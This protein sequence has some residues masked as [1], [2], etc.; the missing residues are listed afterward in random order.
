MKADEEIR[1]DLVGDGYD[2]E[3]LLTA[4]EVGKLLSVPAKSV[5]ELPIPRIRLGVR[6]LR[7]RPHDVDEFITG[8]REIL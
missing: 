2:M 6:R 7:W 5:Y 8:R 3:P 4:K 1:H